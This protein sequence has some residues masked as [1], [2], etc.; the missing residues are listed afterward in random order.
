MNKLSLWTFSN[1]R[2]GESHPKA[3]LTNEQVLQI[4]DLYSKG[5]S[6][7]VIARNFK[8]SKWNVEQIVNNN[9][10]THL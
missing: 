9:T 6:I 7:N 10:W 1:S 4:R 8:V 2:R 3:K 5:F